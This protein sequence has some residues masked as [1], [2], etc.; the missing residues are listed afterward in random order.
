MYCGKL[1]RW[2]HRSSSFRKPGSSAFYKGS[3]IAYDYDVKENLLQVRQEI[4]LDYGAVS[5][6]TVVHMLNGVLN[7][8]TA[9][10]GIAV[11]GIL[12]PGG[13]T[14]DKPVGTVWIA[15]GNKKSWKAEKMFFR[16]DRPRN[17][18]LAAM[19][20]LNHLRKFILEAR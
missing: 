6:E 8:T 20:A 12:G 4:L 18:E 13:G 1:H 16:F 10:Y 14:P 5:E 7:V 19:N 11:S 3:I 15:V 9:D 17:I 2:V